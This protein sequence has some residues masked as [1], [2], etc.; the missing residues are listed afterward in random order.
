MSD[1]FK[2]I[3]ETYIENWD[4]FLRKHSIATQLIPIT[5]YWLDV[6]INCSYLNTESGYS[7]TDSELSTLTEIASAIDVQLKMFPNGAFIRLGS[8]SPKDSWLVYKQGMKCLTGKH[9]VNMFLDSERIS[10]DLALSKANNYTPYIAIR[11]WLEI[12]PW[13]EFRCFYKD[14][15]LVGIS[16]YDYHKGY[17]PEIEKNIS[18]IQL[19]IEI[20][21]KDI[22]KYLPY[23]GTVIADYIYKVKNR[24]NQY[25]N[26][27]ILLELNPW[28]VLTDPC[29]FDWHKNNFEKSEFRYLGRDGNLVVLDMVLQTAGQK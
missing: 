28:T 3:V 6:L 25:I 16:Q 22:T 29:L 1:Y 23:D 19:A 17:Q 12:E 4:P 26:E 9:A 24:D 21:S 18:G 5:R 7:P 20:K 10:D 11:Q 2:S 8:R 27:A 13:Q 14:R 15:K